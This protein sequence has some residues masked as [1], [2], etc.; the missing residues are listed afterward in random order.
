MKATICK[1]LILGILL[2]HLIFFSQAMSRAIFSFVPICQI[3]SEPMY[4]SKML[5]TVEVSCSC[6]KHQIFFTSLLVT[7]EQNII[8]S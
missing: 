8:A 6:G 2:S 3:A 5:T 1:V 7:R 4:T